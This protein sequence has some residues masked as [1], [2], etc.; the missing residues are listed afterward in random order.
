ME[1]L[2]FNLHRPQFNFLYIN[3]LDRYGKSIDFL[4]SANLRMHLR[5]PFYGDADIFESQ[6]LNY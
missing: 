2:G 5:E 1:Y 6:W 3:F 4:S